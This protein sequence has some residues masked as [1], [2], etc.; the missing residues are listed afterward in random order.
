MRRIRRLIVVRTIPIRHRQFARDHVVDIGCSRSSLASE[1]RSFGRPRSMQTPTVAA[2][3]WPAR[4][5][6][7]HS[8]NRKPTKILENMVNAFRAAP[9]RRRNS[10]RN[11]RV[12]CHLDQPSRS[13]RRRVSSR[14]MA[15]SRACRLGCI[16]NRS[17][18]SRIVC[19]N[20][21]ST[22][23]LTLT[24]VSVIPG[25]AQQDPGI[26]WAITSGFR[27]PAAQAPE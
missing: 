19:R 2:L 12:S 9:R 14:R 22:S 27:V 26:S 24:I 5:K 15:R 20:C 8:A 6:S 3:R 17:H 1:A 21:G 13:I 7:E 11:I 25:P 16:C 4:P 18:F 10:C 23:V